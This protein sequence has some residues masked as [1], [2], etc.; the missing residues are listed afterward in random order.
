[1]TN[2]AMRTVSFIQTKIS[3]DLIIS[4][5]LCIADDPTVVESL[6]LIRTPKYE[7]FLEGRERG[8]TVSFELKEKGL[9]KEVAFERDAAAVH[10]RTSES[11][12]GVDLRSISAVDVTEMLKVLKLMNF[13][14]RLK[15]TGLE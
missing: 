6:T 2:E 13:D 14:G 7:V 1:M 15:I 10:L 5:A 12:F 3:D 4:F 9:L 8:V 11:S